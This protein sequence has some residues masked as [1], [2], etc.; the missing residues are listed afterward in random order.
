M[1]KT[2]KSG[3]GTARERKS[4]LAPTMAG[5]MPQ[6][7]VGGSPSASPE[8]G[9]LRKKGNA[10]G[11]EPGG[12]G[13]KK[14]RVQSYERHG[15]RQRVEVPLRL[16]QVPEAAATQANGRVIKSYPKLQDA[17]SGSNF[18]DASRGG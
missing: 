10:K 13:V 15:A 16:P 7:V 3:I 6:G 2:Y 17:W 9:T 11:G 5:G 14:Q 18:W 8:R 4:P 12:P 1:G